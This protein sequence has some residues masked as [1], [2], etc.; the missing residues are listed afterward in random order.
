[1]KISLRAKAALL[2]VL[3]TVVLGAASIILS[4]QALSQI[5]NMT[6]RNRAKD[7]SNTM[8]AILDVGKAVSLHQR[9]SYQ[10]F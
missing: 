9:H 10:C 7:V 6:Y 5:V 8:A 4:S 1:M 3:V 2:I